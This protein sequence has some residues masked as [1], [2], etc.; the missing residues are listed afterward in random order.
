MVKRKMIKKLNIAIDGPAGSGKTV[1]C[2]LLA[3][4]LKY[5]FLD[6]GLLYRHFALF[7]QNSLD[8]KN[9]LSQSIT[10]DF[11]KVGE[12]LFQWQEIFGSNQEKFVSNLEKERDLLGSSE[13][14]ELA[15]RLSPN[16][17]LRKITLDFQRKLTTQK[18]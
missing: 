2:K 18:G 14:G 4:K 11:P 1:I 7:Y 12:I 9:A 6:S 17:S 13:V 3:Q 5:N 8:E 15:S 10:S 16:P